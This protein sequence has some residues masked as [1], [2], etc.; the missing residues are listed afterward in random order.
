[1]GKS[2]ETVH[3]LSFRE[4]RLKIYPRGDIFWGDIKKYPLVCL[5]F[6]YWKS[7][8]EILICESSVAIV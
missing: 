3:E 4:V 7:E 2:L 6:I 5:E 1:M 8:L